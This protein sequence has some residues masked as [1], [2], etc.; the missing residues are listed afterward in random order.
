MKPADK[1]VFEIK[2]DQALL[3]NKP[4]YGLCDASNYWGLTSSDHLVNDF[5]IRPTIGD[6]AL[7]VR[8]ENDKIIGVTG[9]YF[10]DLLNAG[11]IEFEDFS[12]LM[13]EKFDSKP[14]L[15]ASFNFLVH[16]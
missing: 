16:K 8:T 9:S 11:G 7:H 15:Y 4:L 14:L 12:K 13:L 2:D 10:D 6:P 3:L 1:A 5:G